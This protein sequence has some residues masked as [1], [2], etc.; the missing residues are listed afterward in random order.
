M[1]KLSQNEVKL[2][3]FAFFVLSVG[4]RKLYKEGPLPSLSKMA[5]LSQ[6]EVKLRFF[7]FF[8]LSVGGSKLYKE[9]PLQ[10]TAMDR[11]NHG[12]PR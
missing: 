2:R 1:A 10:W 8:V 12:G 7:A 3:F 9:G 4:G 11:D 6:N 5:K